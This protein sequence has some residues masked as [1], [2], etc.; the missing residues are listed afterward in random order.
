MKR[1]NF[2]WRQDAQQ[3][4]SSNMDAVPASTHKMDAGAASAV[5]LISVFAEYRPDFWDQCGHCQ[6]VFTS[7]CCLF[8][9]VRNWI[10]NYF[11]LVSISTSDS[12]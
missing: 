12:Y 11:S 6:R 3:R 9:R 10:L 2:H 4:L 7:L 1:Q 5:L 8:T